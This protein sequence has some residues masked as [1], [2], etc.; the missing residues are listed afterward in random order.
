M[1]YEVKQ[2]RCNNGQGEDDNKT[3]GF[4][5][6]AHRTTYKPCPPYAHH[7]NGIAERMI[8]T[9][10]EKARA[11]MIDSQAPI[12]LWG[13]AVNTGVYLHHRPPNEG[14]KRKNDRDGYQAP[15]ETLYEMVRAFGNPT[16]DADRNK[17]S[18]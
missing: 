1:G 13:E 2:F 8:S 6:A 10:S 3:F 7:T 17:I 11:M 15:Y 14:L 5:L 16:H 12:Q 18:C 4:V 9:I